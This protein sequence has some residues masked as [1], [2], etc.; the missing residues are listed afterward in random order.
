MEFAKVFRQK[1]GNKWEDVVN[2]ESLPKKYKL[3]R[4]SGKNVYITKDMRQWETSESEIDMGKVLMNFAEHTNLKQSRLSEEEH[5]FIKPL[6]DSAYLIRRF[7]KQKFSDNLVFEGLIDR[8]TLQNLYSIV[9]EM[10]KQ[11]K[12]RSKA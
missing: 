1:S 8:R 3:R 11:L 4:L 5:D 6:V 9:V 12:I 10:I 2:F 7:K